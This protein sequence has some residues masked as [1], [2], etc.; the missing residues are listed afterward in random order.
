MKLLIRLYLYLHKYLLPKIED[1]HIS[2]G[3][4]KLRLCEKATK[5]ENIFHLKFDVTE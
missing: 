2:V 3:Q 5:F 4:V 1:S